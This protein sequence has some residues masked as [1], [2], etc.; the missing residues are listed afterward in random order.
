MYLTQAGEFAVYWR[1]GRMVPDSRLK[2]LSVGAPGA[3]SEAVASHCAIGVPFVRVA[4]EIALTC[5]AKQ[6]MVERATRAP[7]QTA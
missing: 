5:N 2:R 4:D 7:H 1:G 6:T 3:T